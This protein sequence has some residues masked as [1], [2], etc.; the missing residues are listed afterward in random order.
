MS[1]SK[2]LAEFDTVFDDTKLYQIFVE[3]CRKILSIKSDFKLVFTDDKSQT[4][5]Y[6]HFIPSENS[7]LVYVGQR[8]MGDVFRTIAH[9]LVHVRQNELKL[10]NSE[11]GDDGSKIENQANSIAGIILRKFGRLYPNIYK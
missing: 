3:Y 2:V 7:V 4:R 9:E 8:S 10:L 6:G 5:T 11:S 1:I